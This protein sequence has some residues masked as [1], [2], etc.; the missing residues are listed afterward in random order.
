MHRFGHAC[1]SVVL[2]EHLKNSTASTGALLGVELG[3]IV[4]P[5]EEQCF[6]KATYHVDRH[7]IMGFRLLKSSSPV[8]LTQ[9]DLTKS[10]H[11]LG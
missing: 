1:R 7:E 5:G 4:Y 3:T 2:C 8:I 6:F 10:E 11:V 9:G